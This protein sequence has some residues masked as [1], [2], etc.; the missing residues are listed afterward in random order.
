MPASLGRRATRPRRRNC[1]RD[2]FRQVRFRRSDD[3]SVT[4]RHPLRRRWLAP[5][6]SQPK[7]YPVDMIALNS[8]ARLEVEQPGRTFPRNWTLCGHVFAGSG[9][10]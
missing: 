7:G 9:T 3:G 10:G 8:K 6:P 2:D 1:I 5:A 4:A